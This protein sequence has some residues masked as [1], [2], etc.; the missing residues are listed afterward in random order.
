MAD[1]RKKTKRQPVMAILTIK[2][3]TRP[4]RGNLQN[5]VDL[6]KTGEEMG[7]LVYVTTVKDLK[8]SDQK[9]VGH[10]FDQNKKTWVCKSFPFPRVIY[11]RIPYRKFELQPEV[12]QK[13]QAC[14]K[15][16]K[17]HLF[18]PF[19]FNKWTLFEWLSKNKSTRS[20]IPKTEKLINYANLESLFQTSPILYLKPVRGKAGRG[21]M[22][23]DKIDEGA[24]VKYRL[25]HLENNKRKLGKYSDLYGLWSYLRG[26]I[27]NTEYIVQQG[28]HL[29][30]SKHRPFDL[31]LLVQKND[32]GIWTVSGIGARVAGKL[33]ITTHVPRGGT[34]DNPEKLLVSKFGNEKAEQIMQHAK[35][36]SLIIAKQIERASGQ[37]MGEMSMDLGV[38]TKGG[39]WFFEANSK[40][41]KFD[42]P[43]IRK[44][45]LLRIIQY[46]KYLNS[47]KS[48]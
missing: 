37:L 4:L 46:C 27:G 17:I 19:F 13:L 16:K 12:H 48:S 6:I 31:R 5:F 14:L 1:N 15:S 2:D 24:S 34:I 11:N 40:P 38:D 23:I 20:F 29:T 25:I 22:R 36:S 33:S 21:I 45:S 9:I 8:L 35:K 42:E 10:Y 47:V 30:R 26:L 32:K 7:V 39:L 3:N 28:I 43:H 44:K 41:M 18:N